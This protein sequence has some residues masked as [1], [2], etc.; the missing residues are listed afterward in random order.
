MELPLPFA[1]VHLRYTSDSC[2]WR[3]F[4]HNLY[5]SVSDIYPNFFFNY[6]FLF[7]S[8]MHLKPFQPK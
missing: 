4:G 2:C 8:I 6:K 1:Q 3:E 7:A 5:F